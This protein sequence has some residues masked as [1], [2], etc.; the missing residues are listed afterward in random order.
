MGV[1][2]IEKE[3]GG[4][5]GCGAASVGD[6]L[7]DAFR[8]VAEG[9]LEEPGAPVLIVAGGGGAPSISLYA[10]ALARALGSERVDYIG[11]DPACLAIAE[12]VGANAIE[13]DKPPSRY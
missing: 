13:M 12:Q 8:C 9:L 11:S 10:A 6:T 1:T 3:K 7:W 4:V 5:A 2:M